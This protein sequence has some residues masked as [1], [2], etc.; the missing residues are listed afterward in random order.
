MKRLMTAVLILSVVATV[1]CKR[2]KETDPAPERQAKNAEPKGAPDHKDEEEHEAL[3]KKV[4]LSQKVITAANI[5]T[6]AVTKEALA[7][8]LALPG[9][10]SVDPDK[11][12]RVSSPV[13]GRI[14]QV[15]F[16]EGSVVQK[17]AALATVRIP[18][19]GKVRAGYAAANAKAM[20]ARTNAK[21]LEEL[22][23]KGLAS[24]QE[25]LNATAEAETLE[26]EAKALD[27]QLQSLGMASTGTGAEL[28]LRSP[29]A[30]TVISRSAV[31]GQPLT[32]EETIANI[33]DLSQVWFLGRV[34]EKDLANLRLSTPAEVELNAFP[35]QRFAG[36]VEYIGRQ[37]DPVGRTV[38]ARI[39]LTDKE[40]I[41]RLGLF[42]VAHVSIG[43][44]QGGPVL[45]VDRNA[46]T[47]IGGKPGV[48]VR[49]PDGDFELHE[50]TL[51]QSN[52]GKV[53]ILSG[54][55]EGEQVV[56]EGAFTLKSAVLRGSLADED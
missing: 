24:N 10:I 36:T 3:T 49:H 41:L 51:G 6:A 16:K 34:F 50:V 9:E 30:G 5:R 22:S 39:R 32:A 1:G 2:N 43:A 33:A 26:A 17:G 28:T 37:I 29:I 21:R 55:R 45:V 12:A 56:V 19:L 46:V 52:L 47:E 14:S 11:N 25:M 31:V 53:Q 4:K 23:Q 42:G 15:M 40:N 7:I 54:L 13:P 48:F 8:T 20:S 38:T 35:K 18:D 27:Q 44:E